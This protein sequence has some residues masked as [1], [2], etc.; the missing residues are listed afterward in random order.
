MIRKILRITETIVFCLLAI[1]VLLAAM[2]TIQKP[3]Q[4]SIVVLISL[5]LGAACIILTSYF[6]KKEKRL[7]DERIKQDR[8]RQEKFFKELEKIAGKE[9]ADQLRC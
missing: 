7:F 3:T 4:L 9:I 2:S 6:S 1:A 5:A 8:I